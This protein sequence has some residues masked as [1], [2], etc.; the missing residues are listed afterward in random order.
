MCLCF[1]RVQKFP[2]EGHAAEIE[3][4]RRDRGCEFRVEVREHAVRQRKPH[5]VSLFASNQVTQPRRNAPHV[6]FRRAN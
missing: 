6:G 2:G 4:F 3:A 5:A 1:N